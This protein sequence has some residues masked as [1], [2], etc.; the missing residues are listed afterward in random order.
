MIVYAFGA[1]IIA[2]TVIVAFERDSGSRLAEYPDALWW[3]VVTV[4]TVGYGDITPETV[5]GRIIAAL[6]MIVGIGL[7]SFVTANVAARFARSDD[8]VER[9]EEDAEFRRMMDEI[10]ELRSEIG[11]LASLVESDRGRASR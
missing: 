4:T 2:T 8:A 7:F 1:L 5:G 9:A 6:L 11:R 3:G 10:K